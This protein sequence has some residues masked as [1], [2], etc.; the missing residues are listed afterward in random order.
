[1]HSYKSYVVEMSLYYGLLVLVLP[2]IYAVTNHLSFLVVFP[3]EWFA[4]SLFLYPIVW[5][6]SAIRYGIHRAK[7]NE[8]IK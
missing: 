6:L 1:M 2:L 4:V 7:K 3:M 5:L 8:L